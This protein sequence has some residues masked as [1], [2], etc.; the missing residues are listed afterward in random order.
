MSSP[1]SIKQKDPLLDSALRPKTWDSYIGQDKIKKNIKIIVSAAKKRDEAPEHILFYGGPGLGKTTLSHIIA[2]EMEADIKVTSGPAIE[3]AGDLV[4]ILS[5]IRYLQ[6]HRKW[7]FS[8]F[9]WTNLL[10]FAKELAKMRPAVWCG[11]TATSTPCAEWGV[12]RT[13]TSW[14]AL[15]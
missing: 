7:L 5:N 10:P 2:H 11:N 3:R 6:T 13:L 9:R 14:A 15:I 8:M 4:A 1:R 12:A